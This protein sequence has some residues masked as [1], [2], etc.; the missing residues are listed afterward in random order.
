MVKT[1]HI[2]FLILFI[3]THETT[4][5]CFIKTEHDKYIQFKD[6]GSITQDDNQDDSTRFDIIKLADGW[7]NIRHT[8]RE[9]YLTSADD[10]KTITQVTEHKD[11]SEWRILC[12]KSKNVVFLSWYGTYLRAKDILGKYGMDQ[13]QNVDSNEKF[14]LECSASTEIAVC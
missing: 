3:Y 2:I 8:F 9:T 1:I 14:V 11:P 12:L 7:Y 4:A 6:D 10:F 5:S 13:V